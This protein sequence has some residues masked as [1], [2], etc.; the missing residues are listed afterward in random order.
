LEKLGG[1]LFSIYRG[2][3]R[4]REWVL[5]CLKGAWPKLIGEKLAAVC[6]PASF[7]GSALAIEVLDRQWEDAIRSVRPELLQKLRSA[8]AGEVSSIVVGSGQ[9]AVNGVVRYRPS[10]KPWPG[11]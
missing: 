9:W 1:V 11:F 5:A 7:D 8:T 4:H 2:T 6:K 3:P 10:P